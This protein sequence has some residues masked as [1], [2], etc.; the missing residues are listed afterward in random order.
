MKM[1][2]RCITILGAILLAT[3]VAA[4]Y[5]G[6]GYYGGG[7]GYDGGVAYYGGPTYYRGYGGYHDYGRGAFGGYAPAHDTWA[8][9]SRGRTSFGGGW[10]GG[11]GAV[12]AGH[13]GG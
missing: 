10:H 8:A 7:G 6:G 9:S 1:G 4:C 3:L 11:G 12:G 13:G 5:D 2:S